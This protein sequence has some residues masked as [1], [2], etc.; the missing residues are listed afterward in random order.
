[1][2]HDLCYLEITVLRP[3]SGI[4][5]RFDMFGLSPVQRIAPLSTAW[6]RR[7]KR[8]AAHFGKSC[9]LTQAKI[10]EG[11]IIWGSVTWVFVYV[12]LFTCL[13][14]NNKLRVWKLEIYLATK[15]PKYKTISHINKHL[16]MS[17]LDNLEGITYLNKLF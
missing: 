6:Q 13:A 1:M 12:F 9:R 15:C 8:R 11:N 16:I 17:K 5:L 4:K 7:K 10:K 3:Q 2:S 14:K